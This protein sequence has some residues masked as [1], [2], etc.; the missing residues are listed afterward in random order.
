[1]TT[2][3]QLKRIKI[4]I[5][6]LESLKETTKKPAFDMHQWCEIGEL[7]TKALMQKQ[8]NKAVKNPCQTAACLAGKA[9]LMPRFRRMGFSWAFS[10][11]GPSGVIHNRLVALADFRYRDR[12]K[13]VWKG[14]FAL[15][16]FFGIPVYRQIF[17]RTYKIRTLFQGINALKRFVAEEDRKNREWKDQ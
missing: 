3:V 15:E 12:H 1:M 7:R 14:T 11:Y 17:M 4:L 8:I 9:G 6:E 5:E 16:K 10:H 2:L 13:H